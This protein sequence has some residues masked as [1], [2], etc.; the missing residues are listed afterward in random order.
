M[1]YQWQEVILFYGL[2]LIYSQILGLQVSITTVRTS[3]KRQ[4]D[5][6]VTVHLGSVV[7]GGCSC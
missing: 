3:F 7:S 5:S 4:G 1:Y 2:I 6:A